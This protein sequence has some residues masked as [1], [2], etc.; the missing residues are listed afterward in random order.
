M[1]KYMEVFVAINGRA[2]TKSWNN[3]F[4]FLYIQGSL[5]KNLFPLSIKTLRHDL[6]QIRSYA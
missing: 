6:Y 5:K 4:S 3:F 1:L 2:F